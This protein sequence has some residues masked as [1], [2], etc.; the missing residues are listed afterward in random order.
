MKTVT[1]ILTLTLAINLSAQSLS[2]KNNIVENASASPNHTTLV[3]AVVAADLAKTLSNKGPFTVFAPTDNA[4]SQLPKGA[5]KTLLMPENKAKLRSIL[6]YHVIKGEFK[7][8]DVM[9]LIKK[10]DGEATVGTVNGSKLNL[11]LKGG[12][13]LIEDQN[14]NVSAVTQTDLKSSNGVIHVVDTVVMP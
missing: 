8:K 5:L 7:A 10:Y 11:T 4:F 3:K 12:N 9:A 6:T 1:F 2:K 13:V 14:G